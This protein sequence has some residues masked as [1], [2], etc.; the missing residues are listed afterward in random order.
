MINRFSRKKC[1][2]HIKHMVFREVSCKEVKPTPVI[3]R[4]VE[5]KKFVFTITNL[6]LITVI[7]SCED[8]VCKQS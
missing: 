6:V 2:S 4:I 3:H 5:Y 1:L 8:K 7:Y